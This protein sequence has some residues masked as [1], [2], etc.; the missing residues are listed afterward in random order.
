MTADA[1]KSA[2]ASPT[3]Y[4]LA[5]GAAAGLTRFALA[6]LD[7]VKTRLQAHNSARRLSLIRIALAR[8]G[9]AGLYHGVLPS[10]AGIV[11]AASVYMLVY[12]SSKRALLRRGQRGQRRLA[13]PVAVALSAAMGDVVAS[14]V[15]V[16]CETLKQRLQ[17]G[18]YRS[19]PHALAELRGGRGVRQLYA[20]L[21]AQIAR[22]VPFAVVEFAAYESLRKRF[23]ASDGFL[24]GGVSGALAAV[25]SNPFDV[26]KTRLMTQVPEAAAAAAVARRALL[27]GAASAPAGAPAAP[28]TAAV[29]GAAAQATAAT[30]AA[31]AKSAAQRTVRAGALPNLASL[32]HV[33]ALPMR[34]RNVLDCFGKIVRY[35]GPH[36]LFRGL[37]PRIAAKTLQSAL[38]FAA[39]EALKRGLA[40]VSQ[41]PQQ[42]P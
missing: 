11:P 9:V 6:P 34:Y 28:V 33:A 42:T 18:V 23:R 17:V 8:R 29:S 38:F 36:A 26:V 27:S 3:V 14:L 7:T 37:A 16:P 19:V 5:G 21:Q 4:F 41:R 31:A 15:R 10:I 20:G 25:V 39:F 12:Q 35:E 13:H 24:L 30:A 40:S 32:E 1:S 2:T 22:D